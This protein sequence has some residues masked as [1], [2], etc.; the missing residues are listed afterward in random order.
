MG[1]TALGPM[2]M[3]CDSYHWQKEPPMLLLTR[4]PG[5]EIVVIDKETGEEIVIAVLRHP[6]HQTGI[7]QIGIGIEAS[8]PR[9]EIYRREV[10][11]RKL[12]AEAG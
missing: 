7:G 4:R 12:A 3:F 11:D 8:R 6:K 10:L 9:F 1:L 2:A 5:E